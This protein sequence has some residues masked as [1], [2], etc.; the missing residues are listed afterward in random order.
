MSDLVKF[1]IGVTEIKKIVSQLEPMF[2]GGFDNL[3]RILFKLDDKITAYATNG[4]SYTQIKFEC[5]IESK[6][7][8]VISGEKFSDIIKVATGDK[9]EFATTEDNRL[10]IKAG[11]VSYRI[12]LIDTENSYLIAP[13]TKD[14]KTFT[15]NAQELKN[16]ISSVSCCIDPAKAHLNCVMIHSTEEE[17][18]KIYVVATDGM[19]LGVSELKATT[20]DVIPNLMI[21]K[22][23]AEYIISIIGEMQG[24]IE[25]K[26]TENSV[27]V[28]TGSIFY[29]TKLLDTSFP[30]YRSVIP[31]NN[32][33][34][35]EAKVVDLKDTI[36]SIAKVSEVTFRIK[37]IITSDNINISCEDNGNDADANLEAT[38]SDKSKLEV[39][40]NYRLLLEILDK[41][42]SSLVRIQFADA[43]T[44]MLIRS[45][46]N[47]NVKYVFMPF[48]N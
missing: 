45:V 17:K 47:E 1:K 28:S 48:V 42:S 35:L 19:R 12:P 25:V 31:T 16:V 29:T 39:V 30:K 36:K 32:N 44:P 43:S 23:A 40:C 6:G 18:N 27:Q 11:R 15:A 24:D 20:N 38:Y 41:I 5:E 34:I 26:Y 3:P 7:E 37:M 2:K 33:K 9:V 13:E 14:A 22:K 4:E 21:P 10:Y 8:F 46:D